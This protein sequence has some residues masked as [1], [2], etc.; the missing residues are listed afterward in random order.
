MPKFLSNLCD[1]I[2]FTHYLNNQEMNFTHT[3]PQ[4]EL[5]FCISSV[6]QRSI[7]NG[8]EYKYNYPCVIISPPYTIHAMSCDDKD[9]PVFDRYVIYFNK[10]F[11]DLFAKE[12]IPDS[13]K[14]KSSGLFFKLRDDQAEYLKNIITVTDPQNET[15]C[16]ITLALILNKLVSFCS[17]KTF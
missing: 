11:F 13:L 3:H 6:Q 5:Y 9:A 15:E 2:L 12:I 14:R 10:N 16:K 17:D 1:E 4:Y 8:E 7:I